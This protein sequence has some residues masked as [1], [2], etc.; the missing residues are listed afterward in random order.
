MYL[1]TRKQQKDG[2]LAQLN[3]ASDYGSEGC[4]F[5]SRGSH[6]AKR[7]QRRKLYF[8]DLR[9]LLFVI[10]IRVA[11]ATHSFV[12]GHSFF[13][14]RSLTLWSEQTHTLVGAN[15]QLGRSKLTVR[16]EQTLGYFRPK[17]DSP[18]SKVPGTSVLSTVVGEASKLCRDRS[19]RFLASEGHRKP[20]VLPDAGKRRMVKLGSFTHYAGK[21]R[22]LESCYMANKR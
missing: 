21:R 2:S 5:E 3:R 19:R 7:P 15:S 16:S 11:L 8:S 4:G 1:C 6:K 13:G 20:T 12:G 9:S 14:R 10:I 22:L 17:H 18:T